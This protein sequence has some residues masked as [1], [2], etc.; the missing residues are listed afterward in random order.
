MEALSKA[1]TQQ[2]RTTGTDGAKVELT[3]DDG[4]AYPMWISVLALS[5]LVAMIPMVVSVRA[6]VVCR[7]L[8]S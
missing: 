8:F 2:T 4:Q 7:S 3:E 1:P 6:V 5:L